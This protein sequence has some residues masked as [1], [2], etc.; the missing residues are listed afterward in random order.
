MTTLLDELPARVLP[1]DAVEGAGVVQWLLD[2]LLAD[3][4]ASAF[5][6]LTDEH[7]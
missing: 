2:D 4:G 5:E 7:R 1:P 6:G 3:T